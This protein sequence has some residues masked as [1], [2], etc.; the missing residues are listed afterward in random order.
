[1]LSTGGMVVEKVEG[2]AVDSVGNVW[3]NN[4]NDGVDDNSGEQLLLNLGPM[5]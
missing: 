4:D 3:I 2:L 1:L 5:N